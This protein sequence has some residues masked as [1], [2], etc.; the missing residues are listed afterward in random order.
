MSLRERSAPSLFGQ[1]LRSPRER[2]AFTALVFGIFGLSLV[3]SAVVVHGRALASQLLLRVAWQRTL[4]AGES[5]APWP[6]SDLE[7]RARLRIPRLGVDQVV[8]GAATGQSLAHGP[9]ELRVE[10]AAPRG[11]VRLLAGHRDTHFS[12]VDDLLPADRILLENPD[13]TTQIYHVAR[14]EVRNRGEIAIVDDPLSPLLYMVTCWPRDALGT[15]S[16]ERLVVTA[17]A[18]LSLARWAR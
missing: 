14:K 2:I 9:G 6:D 13:G 5:V 10:T 8:L 4:A 17:S 16:D 3:G 1:L 7:V 11:V 12:F 18:P 15:P